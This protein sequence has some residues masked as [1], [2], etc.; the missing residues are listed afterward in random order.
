MYIIETRYARAEW[1]QIEGIENNLKNARNKFNEVI[2][3]LIEI[4]ADDLTVVY[5]LR[6]NDTN[7]ISTIL[8]KFKDGYV[9]GKDC[10]ELDEYLRDNAD[11]LNFICPYDEY[12]D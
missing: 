4:S 5:L 11:I 1:I 6:I 2:N 8:N 10:E 7:Y 3:D 9:Y 12:E